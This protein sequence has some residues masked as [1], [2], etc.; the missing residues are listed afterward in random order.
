MLTLRPAGP[1]HA[2][3]LHFLQGVSMAFYVDAMS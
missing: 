3:D 2:K 1:L